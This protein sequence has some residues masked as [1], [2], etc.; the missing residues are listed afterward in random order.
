MEVGG[1]T[2]QSRRTPDTYHVAVTIPTTSRADWY[3]AFGLSSD[4]LAGLEEL[5]REIRT[6]Q[7]AES[8]GAI[9]LGGSQDAMPSPYAVFEVSM[10][11]VVKT[12]V[13]SRRPLPKDWRIEIKAGDK[14]GNL[15]KTARLH[16]PLT[17]DTR[18]LID[19]RAIAPNPTSPRAR[20][21][22][23]RPIE[24]ERGQAP[25]STSVLEW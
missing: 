19:A 23:S 2:F 22:A 17:D 4:Q 11:G 3:R 13:L 1:I 20:P 15:K 16:V 10:P 8:T 25:A 14:D 18:H 21:D 12:S 24:V 7:E 6:K 5:T 9:K